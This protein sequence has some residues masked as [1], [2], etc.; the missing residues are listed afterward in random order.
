MTELIVFG[1]AF[2][3]V[4]IFVVLCFG[5][6]KNKSKIVPP[7]DAGF[8][9]AKDVVLEIFDEEEKEIE[10]IVSGP[11]PE[12]DLAARLNRRKGPL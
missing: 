12:D 9:E 11:K 2:F 7:P 4:G 8:E 1:L 3:V 5:N 10:A 6:L